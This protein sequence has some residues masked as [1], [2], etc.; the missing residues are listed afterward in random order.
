VKS[1]LR[2]NLA[3]STYD[4]FSTYLDDKGVSA[5]CSIILNGKPGFNRYKREEDYLN[6]EK[7]R[8]II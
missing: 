8:T 3:Q 7:N 1:P 2:S 6:I 4:N 5:F